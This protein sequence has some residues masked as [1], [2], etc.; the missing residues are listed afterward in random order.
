MA[1]QT[2]T[3]RHYHTPFRKLAF[4]ESFFLGTNLAVGPFIKKGRTAYIGGW[5]A[6]G[7]ATL[8]TVADTSV[9]CVRCP[10]V[11]LAQNRTLS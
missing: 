4:G 10:G 9:D 7:N 1:Q 5:A 2:Y 11:F 8:T 3:K 6:A